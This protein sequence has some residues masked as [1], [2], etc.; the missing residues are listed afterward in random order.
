ME[1][2][3]QRTF[4][5][6]LLR[7]KRL[8]GDPRSLA[9]GTA[10]GILIGLTPTVPL[11]TVT[12]IGTTLLMRVNTIAALI[13][14]TIVSNPLTFVPQYYLCWKIGNLILPGRL[15]WARLQEVL[16][17]LTDEGFFDSLKA[18]STLSFDALLVMMIG[19][20]LLAIPP[21]L[22]SYYFSLRFFLKIREKRRRKH[23]LD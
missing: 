10:V 16:Q 21:A 4:R 14:A 3:P 12:I 13:S 23:L 8:G 11:H 2:N 6:Y 17:I 1:I 9:M 7:F 18:L 5:Y 20:F 15:T 22:I 19:G